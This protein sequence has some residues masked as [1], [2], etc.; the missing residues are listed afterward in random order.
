MVINQG[1]VTFTVA[2]MNGTVVWSLLQSTGGTKF[3]D[4]AFYTCY[5]APYYTNITTYDYTD[6]EEV[7]QTYGN[8]PPYNFFFGQNLADDQGVTGFGLFETYPPGPV[9]V[10]INGDNAVI[11]NEAFNLY[12][13]QRNGTYWLESPTT[14]K[15]FTIQLGVADV[16]TSGLVAL[17]SYYQPT[18]WSVSFNRS[19]G[20]PPFTY[21]AK[22]T[23][24]VGA[25]IGN[26][27][28][29]F[30]GNDSNGNPNQIAVWF[31]V[32]PP[33]SV[34]VHVGPHSVADL[35]QNVTITAV[36]GGGVGGLSYNW[37]G[38]PPGCAGSTQS[39][40]CQPSA[41][42][43]YLLT[44]SATDSGGDTGVSPVFA[45]VVNPDPIVTV[46][47]SPSR[48]DVNQTVQWY[49][50]A[51]SG[52]GS[53]T[54][55]WPDLFAGCRTSGS[56][57]T[58]TPSTPGPYSLTVVA[59]DAAAFSVTSAPATAQ[60][61]ASPGIALALSTYTVDVH[62]P[63]QLT[64]TASGGAGG[65][66]YAW[67]G[68]PGGCS[69]TAPTATC[70]FGSPGSF[71]VTVS[72]YDSFYVGTPVARAY[73]TVSTDPVVQL[74]A[75][76]PSVDLGQTAVFAVRVTGGAPGYWYAYQN[77]PG[78]CT[79]TDSAELTC[80][81]AAT[82]QYANLSVAVT[83]RNNWTV[84]SSINFTVYSDPV[85]SLV[86]SPAQ[87][88]L[89]DS[90]HFVA[91]VTGGAAGAAY[92]WSNLPGGCQ[93]A[94]AATISCAPGQTGA[95]T[96]TVTITDGDGYSVNATAVLSVLAAP[97]VFSSPWPYVVAGVAIAAVAAVAV[98]LARRRRAEP[99]ADA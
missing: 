20:T 13:N 35:G 30:K 54:Y 77:L 56:I 36:P 78:G 76:T 9:N 89:G 6:Y 80:V 74:T 79:S 70:A 41:T 3:V 72:A 14:A 17:G 49:A 52:S 53:F 33:L 40:H 66:V 95:V 84:T 12:L 82:S 65:F 92:A 39:I 64:A 97:T 10:P 50:S 15:S 93:A 37:S 26:Y 45:F 43:T 86:V 7:Y 1:S 18:G 69:S 21:S 81:P 8:L 57:A 61:L 67:T 62:Q 83:D 96:V 34:A 27:S 38:L 19:S 59:T 29:G 60:V 23:V 25:P 55:A 32:V 63:V 42:G 22:V 88:H 48:V 31:Q 71:L 99:A 4:S 94:P 2:Y 98:V 68:L 51:L 11:A 46:V 28:V 73:V 58:C 16:A 91:S 47:A 75:S 90:V 44:V 85:G 5:Y 24:P 87:V